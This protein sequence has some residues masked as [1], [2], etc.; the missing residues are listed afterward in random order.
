MAQHDSNQG[1][2]DVYTCIAFETGPS[3]ASALRRDFFVGSA[4]GTIHQVSEGSF[5]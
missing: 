2:G 4:S 5:T 3:S 1:V